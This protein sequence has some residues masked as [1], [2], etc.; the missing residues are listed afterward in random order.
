VTRRQ[1]EYIQDHLG[2]RLELQRARIPERVKRGEGAA[3]VDQEQLAGIMATVTEDIVGEIQRSFDFFRSTTGSDRVS[4]VLISGGCAKISQ[5]TKLL[6]ERL[7]IPV[8][9]INPFKNIKVDPKHFD[10]KLISETAPLAA[11]A[12][13]L[14]MRRPNDR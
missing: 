2:Y 8:D 7:E 13:G 4:R 1:F 5:F 10:A 14:A 12:V 6:A 9:I 3:G 11:V